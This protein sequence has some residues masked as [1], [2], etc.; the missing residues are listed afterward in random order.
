MTLRQRAIKGMKWQGISQVFIYTTSFGVSLILARLLVPSDFGTVGLTVAITSFLIIINELGLSAAIVQRKNLSDKHLSTAFIINLCLGV[1]SILVMYVTSPYLSSFFQNSELSNILRVFSS[2]FV[3]GSLSSVQEAILIRNMQFKQ[4]SMVN[5]IAALTHTSVAVSLAFGGYGVWSIIWGMVISRVV[6]TSLYWVLSSWKPIFTFDKKRFR[7]LF[8]FGI[9]ILGTSL[10]GRLSQ[11]L[12]V[13]IIGRL[14]GASSLGIYSFSFRIASMI[15]DQLNGILTKVLFPAYSEI[16]D[17]VEKIRESYLH[18]TKQLSIVSMPLM[19]GLIILAPE[20][21][22]GVLTEKWLETIPVIRLLAI[23]GLMNAIGGGLWGTV[24]KA[25]GYP[26]KVFYLTIVRVFALGSFVIA[27]SYAGMV[28]VAAAVALY[29]LIFRF[30]YQHIVNRIIGISM[31]D[32]LKALHPGALCTIGMVLVLVLVK[33]VAYRVNI[34]PNL[35]LMVSM[36]MLGTCVYIASL[37]LICQPEFDD[38]LSIIKGG[39]R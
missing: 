35:A 11:N 13:M 15:P 4:L 29:G 27:G 39:L 9:S 3:I 18:I 25:Q 8:S 6:R 32:Y 24:L 14:L 21:V 28:G 33:F 38:M 20:F 31:I 30:V 12:D 19:S 22:R 1:F 7:E 37:R 2:V 16:Q 10:V 26:G 23:F 34:I 5:L 36:I 17:N